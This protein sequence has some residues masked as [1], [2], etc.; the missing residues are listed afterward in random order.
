MISKKLLDVRTFE[1]NNVHRA[2][3]E[4]PAFHV[5][6]GIGWINDPNGFSVY[7][8]EY[9]LFHQYHPF[10]V[11]W[12]PMYWGHVKTKDFIKWERL[13][14]AMAPDQEFDRDGCFS[15]TA[16]ELENGQHMLMYTGVHKSV[17]E[18]GVFHELQRQCVAF[19]DGVNYEKYEGNPVISYDQLPEGAFV[20]DF[21]DPKIWKQDGKYYSLVANR[22][23]DGS[24]VLLLYV[25][26]DALQWKYV[27]TFMECKYEYG[28]MWECPD[29]FKLEGKD[30]VIVSP[31]EMEP[32]EYEFH[33][34]H[35]VVA[36]IGKADFEN[37]SFERECVQSVDYGIDFYAPQTL[38]ATDGRR[39]MIGWM[40]NWA[41][42]NCKKNGTALYG[43]MTLPR[44]ISLVDGRLVQ[45]PVRE[46][47]NYRVNKVLHENVVVDKEISLPG[48]KGRTIDMLLRV[49][50]A[51]GEEC[52]EFTVKVGVGGKHYASI[53]YDSKKGLM[54][55]DRKHCGGRYDIV[56]ER[57]FRV[58]NTKD[59][60]DMRIVMDNDSVE[61]FVNEGQQAATFMLYNSLEE[62]DICFDAKG[63][64]LLC[65]E[66]Y[67][68][69]L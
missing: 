28:T 57:T 38:Q 20:Q 33:S 12:G 24:G 8:G 17:D 47:E 62:N 29:V 6:G 66:K 9:H 50:S 55:I 14:V 56:H 60:L 13:P 69:E 15:G 3:G 64:A 42:T 22:C 36:F 37:G 27:N 51:E 11:E 4:R 49:S 35:G 58:D 59:A 30:V 46:L 41:T 45:K 67:D 21:R 25:S 44:E 16:I 48:V 26:E 23:K 40:R 39:I 68:I 1:D 10:S 2:D 34:G 18:E 61:L 5:T 19:G 63:K 52:S 32:E 43:S 65:V 53:S 54:S 31:M 7:K